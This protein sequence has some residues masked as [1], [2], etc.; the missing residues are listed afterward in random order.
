MVITCGV[1]LPSTK[2]QAPNPTIDTVTSLFTF[3]EGL[4]ANGALFQGFYIS[5]VFI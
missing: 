2:P 4:I 5:L 3:I 1:V